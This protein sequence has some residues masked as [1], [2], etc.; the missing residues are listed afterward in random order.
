MNKQMKGAMNREQYAVASTD[1][2]ATRGYN[3]EENRKMADWLKRRGELN[4]SPWRR[5]K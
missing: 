1:T 4:T 5:R 2:P 3:A